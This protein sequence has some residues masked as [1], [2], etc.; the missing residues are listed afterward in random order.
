VI[1]VM[2]QMTKAELF[3]NHD[4]LSSREFH[5]SSSKGVFSDINNS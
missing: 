2:G 3:R 4:N 1:L 5:R